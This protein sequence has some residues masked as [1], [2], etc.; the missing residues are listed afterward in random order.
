MNAASLKSYFSRATRNAIVPRLPPSQS[1]LELGE[2]KLKRPGC[3]LTSNRGVE[4]TTNSTEHQVAEDLIEFDHKHTWFR[5][6]FLSSIPYD[7]RTQLWLKVCSH[8]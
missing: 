3:T 8:L 7:L 4:T 1:H 2:V 5:R 6:R